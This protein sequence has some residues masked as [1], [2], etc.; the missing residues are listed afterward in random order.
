MGSSKAIYDPV[1][2]EKIKHLLFNFHQ[3]GSPRSFE[4][5]VDEMKVV[6][7]TD[8]PED[9]DTYLDFMDDDTKY[10]RFILYYSLNSPRNEQYY[11]EIN[12]NKSKSF[13]GDLS[14]FELET[15]IDDKIL[16]ERQKWETEQRQK[17]QAKEIEEL[18]AK[19]TDAEEYITTLENSVEDL[20][21]NGTKAKAG[22]GEIASVALEGIIRRNPQLLTAIP[23]GEAL[24]GI[25][26]ESPNQKA[27]EEAPKSEVSFQP[28]TEN[29]NTNAE[30]S[31][32]LY[33][34]KMIQE[35]FEPQELSKVWEILKELSE[36]P[37]SIQTVL[38]LLQTP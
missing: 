3:K 9:F 34:V 16:T 1:K 28:K 14:G 37:E 25:L 7:R 4:V 21:T 11:F 22:W 19:L 15:K 18:K 2:V 27:I 24:A 13:S 20:K 26:S 23:G 31:E 30:D 10:I 29:T 33:V 17:E 12:P 5:Y 38:E 35:N 8:N 36:N 6:D 32:R